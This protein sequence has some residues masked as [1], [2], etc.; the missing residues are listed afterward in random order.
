MKTNQ[1]LVVS[2]PR[3]P[4][5]II[6]LLFFFLIIPM[7]LIPLIRISS[8]NK[9]TASHLLS[10]CS[11]EELRISKD[12]KCFPFD[13]PLIYCYSL[14]LQ[15][16]LWWTSLYICLCLTYM[17]M[18]GLLKLVHGGLHILNVDQ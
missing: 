12:R 16:I 4:E 5:E 2:C 8:T 9:S 10:L 7:F 13:N 11:L 17:Y 18:V 1:E 14:P 15:I 3:P 6:R